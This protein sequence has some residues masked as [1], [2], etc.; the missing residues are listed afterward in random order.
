MTLHKF[1]FDPYHW[2]VEH[3]AH[4]LQELSDGETVYA[5]RFGVDY[6][7]QSDAVNI[8]YGTVADTAERDAI[9]SAIYGDYVL[10]GGN[11]HYYAG[12]T[13][14]YSASDWVD[15]AT[16]GTPIV[17]AAPDV[18]P[19]LLTGAWSRVRDIAA[20][21]PEITIPS[22]RDAWT[23]TNATNRYRVANVAE[24]VNGEY[25]IQRR[26]SGGVVPD[27][28]EN[29]HAYRIENIGTNYAVLYD[30]QA[31]GIK[32]GYASSGSGSVTA[33]PA[34]ALLHVDVDTSVE[35]RLNLIGKADLRTANDVDH[36][37]AQVQ[38]ELILVASA[39]PTYD[40]ATYKAD[41]HYTVLSSIASNDSEVDVI[42]AWCMTRTGTTLRMTLCVA[43]IN[44]AGKPMEARPFID[45]GG[46]VGNTPVTNE[47]H[48]PL[49]IA[50][51]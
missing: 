37:S 24:F 14:A 2:D 29:L 49:T 46:T 26:N 45:I 47:D 42:A 16:A 25:L 38:S 48:S 27:L 13:A 19:E 51:A 34:K 43:Q 44:D 18:A 36:I 1:K 20:V 39:S 17:P 22:K 23:S 40:A 31:D 12:K 35:T 9:T 11:G 32:G 6:L 50:S 41:Q 7:L 28:T 3:A 15:T 5:N 33:Y 4:Y 30:L 21:Y 8:N 10:I